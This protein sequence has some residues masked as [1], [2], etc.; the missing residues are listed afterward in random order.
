MKVLLGIEKKVNIGS[1]IDII[2]IEMMNMNII[3]H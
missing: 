2:D 1:Y 3:N